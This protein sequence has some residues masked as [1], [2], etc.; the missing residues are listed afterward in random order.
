MPAHTIV[1]PT[2]PLAPAV[3]SRTDRYMADLE[4]YLGTLPADTRAD[5]LSNLKLW[6]IAEYDRWTFR[7]DGD[8]AT[9]TDLKSNAADFVCTIAAVS[10]R[11]A[12]EVGR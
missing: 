4:D 2:A 9:A 5:V 11:H 10:A 8:M 1:K 3:S 12:R 6:W 7:V